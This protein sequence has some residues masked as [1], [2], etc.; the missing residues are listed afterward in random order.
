MAPAAREPLQLLIERAMAKRPENRLSAAELS[1]ELRRVVDVL[2]EH[3][4]LSPVAG[5]GSGEQ[6][7]LQELEIAS[8][9]TAASAIFVIGG[10]T[11]DASQRTARDPDSTLRRPEP[12]TEDTGKERLDGRKT[13]S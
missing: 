7:S 3:A 8:A 13:G 2:G 12:V 4:T 10:D 9:N 6:Q 1:A 11:L 5:A